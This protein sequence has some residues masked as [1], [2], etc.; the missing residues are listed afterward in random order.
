MLRVDQRK[1]PPPFRHHGLSVRV[2]KLAAKQ[3]RGAGIHRNRDGNGGPGDLRQHLRG[4]GP[5]ENGN[6]K[7]QRRARSFAVAQ[8]RHRRPPYRRVIS[9]RIPERQDA[10]RAAERAKDV[11]RHFAFRFP[12]GGIACKQNARRSVVLSVTHLSARAFPSNDAPR[13]GQ[14]HRAGSLGQMDL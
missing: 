12:A 5:R 6:R 2:D 1:L 13:N 14:T 4:A 7:R 9:R 3:D 8:I 11:P 10:S